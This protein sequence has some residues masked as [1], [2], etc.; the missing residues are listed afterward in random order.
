M[1]IQFYVK[2]TLY[3]AGVYFSGPRDNPRDK[4]FPRAIKFLKQVAHARLEFLLKVTPGIAFI[5]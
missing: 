3:T 2:Q 1:L 5:W 4:L